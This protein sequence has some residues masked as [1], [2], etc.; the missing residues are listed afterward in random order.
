LGFA[1]HFNAFFQAYTLDFRQRR[2]KDV[3]TALSSNDAWQ[4]ERYA[5]L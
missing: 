2:I 4:R 3:E 5:M 1:Q